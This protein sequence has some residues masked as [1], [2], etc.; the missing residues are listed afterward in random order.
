[1]RTAALLAKGVSLNPEAI[2]AVQ[3]LELATVNGAQAL[4]SEKTQVG[5]VPTTES[6]LAPCIVSYRFIV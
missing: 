4:N 2:N 6:S 1:M 3:A 5:N